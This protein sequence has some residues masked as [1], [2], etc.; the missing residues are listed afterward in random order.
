MITQRVMACLLA[1]SLFFC[2]AAGAA[3]EALPQETEDAVP[4]QDPAEEMPFTVHFEQTRTPLP[5]LTFLETEETALPH[6]DDPDFTGWRISAP[7]PEEQ[8]HGGFDPQT[9]LLMPDSVL[10]LNTAEFIHADE[11]DQPVGMTVLSPF[12]QDRRLTLQAVYAPQQEITIEEAAYA[13]TPAALSAAE[14]NAAV[15]AY[16]IFT[17]SSGRLD[18]HWGVPPASASSQIVMPFDLYAFDSDYY[19]PWRKYADQITEAV[20]HN[21]YTPN[22]VNNW[23][24]GCS[25]LRSVQNLSRMNLSR[26]RSASSMFNG[27]SSL[28][29]LDVSGFQTG[30]ITNFGSMFFGCSSLESLDVSGWDTS[31]GVLFTGTFMNCT[32]LNSLDVSGFRVQNAESLSLMFR[33]CSSLQHLD[34]SKWDVSSSTDDSGMFSGCSVLEYLDV[35]GWD[36]SRNTTLF[37]TFMSCNALQVDGVENWDVSHV[38]TLNRTFTGVTNDLL[39]LSKWDTSS[40]TS[41]EWTFGGCQASEIRVADWDVSHVTS[42]AN[43]ATVTHQLKQFDVSAWKTSSLTN[44]DSSFRL[45]TSLPVLAVENWDTSGV[46]TLFQTFQYCHSLQQLD[47]SRWDTSSNTTLYCTFNECSVLP[48]LDPSAW[49]TD[50]VTNMRWTFGNCDALTSLDASG[51]KTDNV[52]EM[53]HVFYSM[54]ALQKLDIGDDGCWNTENVQNMRSMFLEDPNLSEVVLSDVFTFLGKAPQKDQALLMQA[55]DAAFGMEGAPSDMLGSWYCQQTRSGGKAA[56]QPADLQKNYEG[57]SLAGV[58]TWA[59]GGRLDVEVLLEGDS[60]A[61]PE[62][63]SARVDAPVNFTNVGTGEPQIPESAPLTEDESVRHWTGSLWAWNGSKMDVPGISGI[64]AGYSL[65]E[66]SGAVDTASAMQVDSNTGQARFVYVNNVPVSLPETGSHDS[67]LLGIL[68]LV[69]IFGSLWLVLRTER[70]SS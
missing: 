34:V 23:F 51:W 28:T 40:N 10:E 12:Y 24:R 21:Q 54:D 11:P 18:F 45:A 36:I 7:D 68:S 67:L 53:D 37:M 69:L 42:M 59:R 58:W 32:S 17:P 46:T 56:G 26:C 22:M 25:H 55:P 13:E 52:Q 63:L 15:Q 9:D 65:M 30:K 4:V 49:N 16:C 2:P 20:F 62:A 47:V 66:K 39:D 48:Q 31:S 38:T 1:V 8:I 5:D 41:L 35:S 14:Q 57:S 3:Q 19:W 43:M 64:P 33:N 6:V 70:K 60:S 50:S 29:S 44:L 27:C 61:L